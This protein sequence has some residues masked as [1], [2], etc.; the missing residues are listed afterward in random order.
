MVDLAK[1]FK[2]ISHGVYVIGVSDGQQH[3]AFTAAWVMQASFD[4]PLLVF[5]INPQHYSYSLLQKGGI[6]SVN[7]LRREQMAIAEHFG[8]PGQ[9]DK[10]SALRW[11]EAK[12]GAPV[13]VDGLAYFDCAVSHYCPAGDHQLAVCRVI[14]AALLHP[15]APLLY[16]DTGDMDG[17]SKL[18]RKAL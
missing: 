5:S 6:C 10:M 18:Y 9:R 16:V 8:R 7:V 4:P 17:S 2:Y 3:N 15:D 1:V 11:R 13:L 14:D 12:T